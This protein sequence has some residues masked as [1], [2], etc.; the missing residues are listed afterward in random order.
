MAVKGFR[1]RYTSHINQIRLV[2]QRV[3]LPL[4]QERGATVSGDLAGTWTGTFTQRHCLGMGAMVGL[5]GRAGSEINSLGGECRP[6]RRDALGQVV[7]RSDNAHVLPAM[8]ALTNGGHFVDR[9]PPGMA[10]WAISV[11]A[12]ARV[13]RVQGHC[14]RPSRWRPNVLP[15]SGDMRTLG[16]FGGSGGTSR[17]L[18][19]AR[20]T[21]VV[22]LDTLTRRGPFSQPSVHGL[23][24]ICRG[25]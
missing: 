16:S 10:M 12:G 9:C 15:T 13:N 3:S 22:G 2:C 23:R 1:G 4:S 8:G 20:G 17:M 18:S 14:V 6:T 21:F 19:C 7:L 11:R 25:L 24:V 5:Y